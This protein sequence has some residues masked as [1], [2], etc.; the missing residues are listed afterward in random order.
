MNEKFINYILI[1]VFGAFIGGLLVYNFFPKQIIKEKINTEFITKTDTITKVKVIRLKGKIK[2]VFI[3]NP[4]EYEDY[5]TGYGDVV[6]DKLTIA[7]ADTLF[8]DDNLDLKVKYFFEPN[9]FEINYKLRQPAIE[10]RKTEPRLFLGI[11]AGIGYD[12]N[13]VSPQIQIGVYYNLKALR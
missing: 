1:A 2:E 4:D 12:F 7:M 3:E 5:F 6:K 11:G 10:F 9:L 8:K 13:K